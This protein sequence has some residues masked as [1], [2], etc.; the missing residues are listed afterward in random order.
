VQGGGGGTF[1]G[2]Y[3]SAVDSEQA[4]E[5]DCTEVDQVNITGEFWNDSGTQRVRLTGE[6]R[7]ALMVISFFYGFN[8]GEGI[9]K[10]KS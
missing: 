10:A 4:Y 8:G 9:R 2:N 5:R 3:I 7:G 6:W 1:S